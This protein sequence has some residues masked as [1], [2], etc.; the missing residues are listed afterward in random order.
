[1]QTA[2][3]AWIQRVIQQP[4]AEAEA[5]FQQQNT[6]ILNVRTGEVRRLEATL[7]ELTHVVV[8]LLRNKFAKTIKLCDD[9]FLSANDLS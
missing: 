6:K 5:E 3:Y 7:E 8:L 2:I 4:E 9:A 1:M